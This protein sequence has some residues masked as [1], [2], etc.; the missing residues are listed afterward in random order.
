[1]ISS[2]ESY[3][4]PFSLFSFPS[5]PQYIRQRMK[6]DDRRSFLTQVIRLLKAGI[7]IFFAIPIVRYVFY[8][9]FGSGASEDLWSAAGSFS[10]IP[11]GEPQRRTFLAAERDGWS[12]R[13]VERSVWVIR[14]TDD[15]TTVF[16]AVCPHLGCTIGW[17]ADAQTFKCPCHEAAFSLKGA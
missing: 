17:R 5:K 10:D 2:V 6:S 14:D 9:V 16:N 8:P 15:R 13:L 3:I 11:V 12:E 4:R 1:M 7:A